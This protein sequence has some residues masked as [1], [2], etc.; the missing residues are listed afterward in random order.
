[1][2]G[3]NSKKSTVTQN[4]LSPM[5]KKIITKDS[6]EMSKF[7]TSLIEPTMHKSGLQGSSVLDNQ[8]SAEFLNS[9]GQSQFSSVFP[10]SQRQKII[11]NANRSVD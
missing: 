4:K 5:N 3:T 1:M 6:V 2:Y 10:D 7:E 9:N 11:N 8:N